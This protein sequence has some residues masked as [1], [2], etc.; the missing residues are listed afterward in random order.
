MDFIIGSA[1]SKLDPGL[2]LCISYDIAC[3]YGKN[4]WERMKGLPD[5][6]QLQ[7]RDITFKVPNFH[8]PAHKMPCHSP[9]SFHFMWGAG[10][11]NGEGVEQNWEFTNGAGPSTKLMGPGSRQVTL[12]DLFGFHNYRR[13]LAMCTYQVYLR[14]FGN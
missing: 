2:P 6:L 1:L 13:T 7:P 5:D 9:F 11:T 10:K 4:F 3:Q 12:E 14:L 8:L